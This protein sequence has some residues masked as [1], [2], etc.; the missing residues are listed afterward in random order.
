MK[1]LGTTI[2][3]LLKGKARYQE[4][5]RWQQKSGRWVMKVNGKVVPIKK[6][7]KKKKVEEVAEHHAAVAHEDEKKNIKKV[8]DDAKKKPKSKVSEGKPS[9]K[10]PK[11][12]TLKQQFEEHQKLQQDSNPDAGSGAGAGDGSAGAEH[13]TLPSGSYSAGGK[14]ILVGRPDLSQLPEKNHLDASVVKGMHKHQ[15]DAVNLQIEAYEKGAPAFLNADGTGAGKTT[16]ILAVTSHFAK[17]S[18]DP[19]L[20][21][22]KNSNI[23]KMSFAKDAARM[24][25]EINHVTH[26]DEMKAGAINICTYSTLSKMA[27][28][29]SVADEK[30]GELA[31]HAWKY[32]DANEFSQA[33]GASG[34]TPEAAYGIFGHT[35]YAKT[36]MANYYKDKETCVKKAFDDFYSFAH[37]KNRK[38]NF[39]WSGKAM[40]AQVKQGNAVKNATVSDAKKTSVVMFD[41]AHE[42]KN[43]DSGQAE[44]GLAMMEASGKTGLF[45]AT[46][47]DKPEH[48][49]YIA[50]AFGLDYKKVLGYAGYSVNN[51]GD[52][53]TN[54]PMEE[55]MNLLGNIFGNLTKNGHMVKREVSLKNMDLK[56]HIVDMDESD[57]RKY[58]E[59]EAFWDDKI[60]QAGGGPAAMNVSGQ[61]T[62]AMRRL[63]ESFKVKHI[64][65][66]AIE[67]LKAG[68]QAILFFDNVGEK[69]QKMKLHKEHTME[70]DS[71][72]NMARDHFA[73]EL[74]KH[75]DLAHVKI[76]EFHGQ[77]TAGARKR[78]QS[79][80][81]NGAAHVF[82]TT[83]KSG[84]PQP[85]SAKV[86]TPDGWVT[87][88]SLKVGDFVYAA[89]GTP[90]KVVSISEQG[91]Q[92][93]YKISTVS[94]ASTRS[95][96]DHLWKVDSHNIG[97][98][99]HRILSLSE[100]RKRKYR[101]Y[102]FPVNNVV[103]FDKRS[104]EVDPYILG[105]M[106]GDGCF[107][108]SSP[109]YC[110]QDQFLADE[111]LKAVKREG[112]CFNTKKDSKGFITGTISSPVINVGERRI[113]KKGWVIQKESN[114][115]W[116]HV[117]RPTES[118][119]RCGGNNKFIEA[120]EKIGLWGKKGEQKF[121][122]EDYLFNDKKTRLRVLQGLMDTDGTVG[123]NGDGTQ[124]CNK[125]KMLAD[126]VTHLVRSLGGVATTHKKKDG[127]YYVSVGLSI[128]PFR[129]PRKIERW[130]KQP[131]KR[132]KNNI[133]SI[134]KAEDE[135]CRCILIED[136]SHLYITDDFLVTHNTGINLDDI[137]GNAPRSIHVATAPYSANEFIQILGRGNRVTTKSKLNVHLHVSDTAADD[138]NVD[139][140]V[141]KTKTL[142]ASVSGDYAGLKV[143]DKHVAQ[144]PGM[145]AYEEIG[146][147]WDAPD[148]P[149]IP[150]NMDNFKKEVMKSLRNFVLSMA[151]SSMFLHGPMLKAYQ[152]VGP[153]GGHYH[154]SAA[155]NK[156]YETEH[157]NHFHKE[158]SASNH[159]DIVTNHILKMDHLNSKGHL[160]DN[161]MQRLM[162]HAADRMKALMNAKASHENKARE[163]RAAVV[164]H[165]RQTTEGARKARKERT[166]SKLKKRIL[167]AKKRIELYK[168][169]SEK[170]KAAHGHYSAHRAEM[171]KRMAE[172]QPEI[173][174]LKQTAGKLRQYKE[175][176][177]PTHPQYSNL[178][179]AIQKHSAKVKEVLPHYEAAKKGIAES[180][181]KMQRILELHN[182]GRGAIRAYT[183]AAKED[184]D[185][186][187]K[188]LIADVE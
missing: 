37:G 21:V 69:G 142:G 141:K 38:V 104:V 53:T 137:T 112:H 107:T 174:K 171:Q 111:M 92:P 135:L 164:T 61:A 110:S 59:A 185:T 83:P 183:Q 13:G 118:D 131:H 117:G 65:S 57:K 35:G 148:R 29:V 7:R 11:H 149:F 84:G 177:Q 169:R 81:Q 144:L 152:S 119:V 22:T 16:E 17:K 184:I 165:K 85:Y 129:L 182:K 47:L 158:I 2:I 105:M 180:D 30:L 23:I 124:F 3:D 55:R 102:R 79:D 187:R 143:P 106:L 50:H 8:K 54:M 136:P 6:G 86:L 58:N 24:G 147:Q 157:G 161:D 14:E 150:M 113:T 100:I 49:H 19:A 73:E 25:L 36:F 1:T 103:K 146:D 173:D 78:A 155:G 108:K 109:T 90:S 71:S 145:A 172:I 18:S 127:V 41:E 9:K 94:G 181:A 42:L 156:V 74:K 5:Q 133:K 154:L 43:A 45:T 52:T 93:T 167:T 51:K 20:I 15:A 27:R 178:I 70:Y 188:S 126:G 75:P 166:D 68:R 99:K 40:K 62:L 31:K 28:R 33:V 115:K 170:L 132:M 34:L 114:K 130:K 44:N 159:P 138:K 80:F 72:V 98:R 120:F 163:Q 162:G 151:M 46:P 63:N 139:A 60:D 140:L 134:V 116:N 97:D 48:M 125:S 175:T 95:T 128:C 82:I 153:Q 56:S 101:T 76:A 121:I 10:K 67:D 88:G 26:P 77:M 39:Q 87:M 64:V 66:K 4:G 160:S 12:Q 123:K 122:P 168:E 176:M 186:M 89:N 91:V 179:A 96:D 32:K